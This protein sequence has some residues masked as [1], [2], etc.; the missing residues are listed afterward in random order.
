MSAVRI[1]VLGAL[2]LAVAALTASLGGLVA[3][4]VATRDWLIEHRARPLT[5][6][7]TAFTTIGSSAVL[8]TLAFGVMVWLGVARRRREAVLV[9]GTTAGALVLSPVLKNLVE[10]ARPGDAHLVLV[11]SWAYPSG[12]SLTSTAVIGVLTTLA[13][14]H[15]AS[16]RARAA[17]LVAGAL[18]IAAVGI[19][20]VY[21]GVHWPTDVL[22]GWL[23]G[24]LW[25]AVCLL[26][27]DRAARDRVRSG[28]PPR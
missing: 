20:R 4:D 18:L 27:Y 23:I 25:L 21:L 5:A 12:H 16:R 7:M 17:V 22:A 13:A 11:N 6:V 19:S 28:S 24:A 26:V 15:L 10:R 2:V 14:S 8:V 9:G 1:A 3:L